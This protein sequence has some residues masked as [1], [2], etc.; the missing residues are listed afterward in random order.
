MKGPVGLEL[1]RRDF[2]R[3]T[4]VLGA[5]ALVASAMPVAERMLAAN[6]A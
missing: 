3:D 5:A 1:S 2:L 4:S 6:T